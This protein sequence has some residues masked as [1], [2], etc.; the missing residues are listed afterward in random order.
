MR[1]LCVHWQKKKIA[2]LE[3]LQVTHSSFQESPVRPS[4]FVLL[5]D[6]FFSIL[7]PI[8]TVHELP[9][10]CGTWWNINSL[11]APWQHL[12]SQQERWERGEIESQ[13][14]WG[15]TSPRQKGNC[16]LVIFLL[17]HVFTFGAHVKFVLLGFRKGKC[18]S[19]RDKVAQERKGRL[20]NAQ[21]FSQGCNR[22]SKTK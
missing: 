12:L 3:L 18:V 21:K 4:V 10:L 8:R 1:L 7:W 19:L 20:L 11:F 9:D 16:V 13:E 6:S 14:G 2:N 22:S 5:W 15:G 17:F